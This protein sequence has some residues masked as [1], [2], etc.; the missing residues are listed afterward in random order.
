ML[1]TN[2][3]WQALADHIAREIMGWV[4]WAE[5]TEGE[6]KA[7]RKSHI[8]R[9]SPYDGYWWQRNLAIL[10]IAVGISLWQPHVNIAQAILVLDR[11]SGW[12]KGAMRN[13]F[14]Q[15]R[16]YPQVDGH[17]YNVYLRK[18]VPREGSQD[19]RVL[20]HSADADNRERA[21]CLA[22][23]QCLDAQKVEQGA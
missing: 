5:L 23:E 3:E 6:Q 1:K 16:S 4:K 11:M 21:I 9:H 20:K 13:W 8:W 19:W 7:V 14:Y 12:R 17:L 2:A 15:I 10:H 22:I 18:C